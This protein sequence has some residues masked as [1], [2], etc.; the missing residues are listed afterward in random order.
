MKRIIMAV[1]LTALASP[2]FAQTSMTSTTKATA[3]LTG[4]CLIGASNVNFGQLN[5]Q[6]LPS[7]IVAQSNM[8]LHCTTATAYSINLAYGGIYGQGTAAGGDYYVNQGCWVNCNPGHSNVY[9][10]YDSSGKA[11]GSYIG[12]S[13]PAT[14]PKP[15]AYGYMVGAISGDQ[16]QYK[17][18]VPGNDNQVWNSGEYTYANTG[19]GADQVFPIKATATSTTFPTPDS[20]SDT[21]TATVTY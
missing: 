9:Y 13:P 18:T 6:A 20:Y 3:T 5:L 7:G 17:I 21:V 19:T 8:T 15:Y 10:E 2:V 14:G 11:I 12:T 16:I 1:L 4:S